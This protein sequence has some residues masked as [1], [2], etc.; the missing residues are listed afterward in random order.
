[1]FKKI[2]FVLL[3]IFSSV[4]KANWETLNSG[5][6]ANINGVA[7]KGDFGIVATNNGL[8]YT[9]NGGAS[10]SDWFYIHPD[11]TSVSSNSAIYLAT[12]FSDVVIDLSEKD[13]LYACGQDTVNKKAVIID[14]NVNRPSFF[15]L[16]EYG[17]TNSKFNKVSAKNGSVLAGGDDGKLYY[18][19]YHFNGG[20]LPF[21]KTEDIVDLHYANDILV[22]TTK[23]VYKVNPLNSNLFISDSITGL[24]DIIAS[25][26]QNGIEINLIK[27]DKYSIYRLFDFKQE[28]TNYPGGTLNARDIFDECVATDHGLYRNTKDEVLEYIPMSEGNALNTIARDIDN[29]SLYYTGG[30]NGVLYKFSEPKDKTEPFGYFDFEP[31]CQGVGT[32]LNGSVG[33]STTCKWYLDGN[34]F[35]SDCSLKNFAFPDT[36]YHNMEVYLESNGGFDT[37]RHSFYIQSLP[38]KNLNFNI[39]DSVICKKGKVKLEVLSPEKDVQYRFHYLNDYFDT[40]PY[41][42]G[43]GGST[44]T[45]ESS[46]IT[47]SGYLTISSNAMRSHCVHNWNDS[48]YVSVQNTKAN[49]RISLINGYIGEK[50]KYFNSSTDWDHAIWDIKGNNQVD[51][52]VDSVLEGHHNTL[53]RDS[54]KLMV[55]TNENCYDS[56]TRLGTNIIPVPTPPICWAVTDS[57]TDLPWSYNESQHEAFFKGKNSIYR[58]GSFSNKKF[59]SNY[60]LTVSNTEMNGAFLN[61][62]DLNGTLKWHT[63]FEGFGDGRVSAINAVVED[64]QE[65]I[66]TSSY[67][68]DGYVSN[69]EQVY[70]SVYKNEKV[71]SK[72]NNLG[73][74][75]DV[76]HFDSARISSL[77]VGLQNE[78]FV[79][80]NPLDQNTAECKFTHKGTETVLNYSNTKHRSKLFKFDNNLNLDWYVS[81][82]GASLNNSKVNSKGEVILVL[83]AEEDIDFSKNGILIKTISFAPPLKN[84][85]LIVKIDK[86]GNY[87]WHS[88]IEKEDSPNVQG[89]V[90]ISAIEI[91]AYDDIFIGQHFK[92]NTGTEKLTVTDAAGSKT[93][94]TKKAQPIIKLDDNGVFKWVIGM[95]KYDDFIYNSFSCYDDK[96]YSI[97][98]SADYDGD[99]SFLDKNGIGVQIQR[100]NNLVIQC[101]G[102]DGEVKWL[103]PEN[104]LDNFQIGMFYPEMTVDQDGIFINGL[105]KNYSNISGTS[106]NTQVPMCDGVE[107]VFMRLDPSCLDYVYPNRNVNEFDLCEGEYYKFP[108]GF[109]VDSVYQHVNDTLKLTSSYNVDSLVITKVTPR[110]QYTSYQT[111]TICDGETYIGGDGKTYSNIKNDTTIID[112]LTSVYGCDSLLTVKLIPQNFDYSINLVNN[113]IFQIQSS[114]NYSY[115]W[116]RCGSSSILSFSSSYTPQ[117]TDEYYVR[118]SKNGCT[119][120]TTCMSTS[121]ISSNSIDISS[122]INIYPNPSTGELNVISELYEVNSVKIFSLTGK[123]VHLE[124]PFDNGIQ[125][126][127]PSGTYIVEIEANGNLVRKNFVVK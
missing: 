64:S 75:L 87:I 40:M 89:F 12:V 41:S 119:L 84:Y 58:A 32:Q 52:S 28:I 8:F 97:G 48:V 67:F 68:L 98:I 65:N 121:N 35:S 115:I 15:F 111:K 20:Y 23:G 13:R 71:I 36:G 106:F 114:Q 2:L 116:Y 93:F 73:E 110:D 43:D 120:N 122:S 63:A 16:V 108:S 107:G 90:N 112:Q 10:P 33:S 95:N 100:K 46:V 25:D 69:A 92:I 118:M 82:D 51:Y 19:D 101:Y 102:F 1:M 61:K 30:D 109:E 11:S 9:L 57:A 123:L 85:T 66:F 72:F 31:S 49:F 34:L 56:I 113:S 59:E 80:L 127:I 117:D 38:K 104:S 76:I 74:I 70:P 81:C 62:Y 126:N 18:S 27:N 44:E 6:S 47:K 88:I 55:W 14:I 29:Y 26:S 99:I 22:T 4:V 50:V 53:G 125:I 42:E 24:K 39:F 37:A 54:V 91:N 77:G 94:I 21:S 3:L 45:T 83:S 60:G 105:I 103:A 79:C 86:D 124:E 78:L 7:F 96:L 5:I 17:I